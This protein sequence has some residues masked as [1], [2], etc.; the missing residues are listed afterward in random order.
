MRNFHIT[1]EQ[2]KNLIK[3]GNILYDE[4]PGS[5]SQK[6]EFVEKDT[7]I[8]LKTYGERTPI[9]IEKLTILGY[10]KESTSPIVFSGYKELLKAANLTNYMKSIFRGKST[11]EK[12][13]PFEKAG[14]AGKLTRDR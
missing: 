6:V 9:D 14:L 1:E 11:G 5:S 10:Q 7:K 2:K 3:Y 13:A 12:Y 4:K 8:Y